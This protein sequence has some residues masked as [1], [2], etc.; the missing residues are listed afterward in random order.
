MPLFFLWLSFLSPLLFRQVGQLR[1]NGPFSRRSGELSPPRGKAYSLEEGI[2]IG[3]CFPQLPCVWM[4]GESAFPS[5]LLSP[6]LRGSVF[7][8][9]VSF[10]SLFFC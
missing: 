7:V 3:V 2:Q 6:Y 10:L 8:S 9:H 5:P 1:V 4:G